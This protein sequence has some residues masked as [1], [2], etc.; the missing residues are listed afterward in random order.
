MWPAMSSFLQ[1]HIAEWMAWTFQKS[2]I[3]SAAAINQMNFFRCLKI[4]G[5]A[6]LLLV[7]RRTPNS[8][9]LRNHVVTQLHVAKDS[10][11]QGSSSKA[12]D[13]VGRSLNSVR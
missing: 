9:E 11:C 8:T 3:A 5:W 2:R 6:I 1:Q 10:T 4:D 13:R 12:S 7:K